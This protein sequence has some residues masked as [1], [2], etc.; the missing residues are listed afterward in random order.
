M[1]GCIILDL[2]SQQ[3]DIVNAPLSPLAV[4]A[5]AGSGKTKTAVYRLAKIRQDLDKERGYIALLSFSKIAVKTFKNDFSSHMAKIASK[6]NYSERVVI[7]TLD[8]FITSN[9]IRPH[10][11]NTMK[12]SVTPFLITGGEPFLNNKQYKFWA[13]PAHGQDFPIPPNDIGKITIRLATNGASAYYGSNGNLIPVNNWLKVM[14]KIGALGGYTHEFGKYWASNTLL[15][16]KALLGAFARRYP[17]IIIDEAQDIDQMH[18][19]ILDILKMVGI[20]LTLIGDPNQSI[21]EF[22]GADGTYLNCFDE[23]TSNISLPLTMNHRSIEDIV[24]VA[25]NVSEFKNGHV[26]GKLKPGYGAYYCTY[27][28]GKEQ[29]LIESFTNKIEDLSLVL[30]N[31]AVLVRARKL[32][33]ELSGLNVSVGQGKTKLLALATIKRDMEKDIFAAFKLLV[34]CIV[35]LIEDSPHNFKSDIVNG[36]K[37]NIYYETKKRI[38]KFLRSCDEGLPS[39]NL[40]AKSEWHPLLKPRMTKLLSEICRSHGFKSVERVG[41]KLAATKLTDSVFSSGSSLDLSETRRIRIDTVHQSKGE[42]LDAVMYVATK[43]QVRKLIDGTTTELGRI[44]YVAITRAR[45]LFVLAIS[46]TN[47]KELGPELEKLG[48]KLW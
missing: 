3:K 18:G 45:D 37:D 38:W 42:S 1:R 36:S 33:S 39:A 44:G 35:S 2:S 6:N 9:I 46:D 34:D 28:K 24:T 8:S 15:E 25:S 48:F 21:Y 27:K 7:E 43:D 4:V 41:N 22:A 11:P 29:E 40:K 30:D 14:K 12:S 26:R 17:Q 31:S 16:N 47:A 19:Y 20:N 10:S 23:N 32:R 5:C 13:S